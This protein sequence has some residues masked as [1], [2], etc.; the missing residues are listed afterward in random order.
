MVII[1]ISNS[2]N[3]LDTTMPTLT[4]FF[5]SYIPTQVEDSNGHDIVIDKNGQRCLPLTSWG[6]NA[7]AC[8][9]IDAENSSR[10]YTVVSVTFNEG[11]VT[12]VDYDYGCDSTAQ[13][14]GY[15]SWSQ[16]VE[17]KQAQAT[18]IES[19]EIEVNSVAIK[20]VNQGANPFFNYWGYDLA[21]SIS[22]E[23]QLDITQENNDS[24]N[25]QQF[26]ITVHSHL[27]LFPAHRATVNIDDS[28]PI[29]IFD[30]KP[31]KGRTPFDL[32]WGRSMEI[33]QEL[34]VSQAI[35]PYQNS[36]FDVATV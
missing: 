20:F 6:P 15:L 35:D 3:T 9:E 21:P 17:I 32:F 34:V 33:E 18:F 4:L 13:H 25:E 19:Y 22:T 11:Q 27:T 16:Q 29:P 31:E 8:Y 26:S 12:D 1:A 24:L 36:H 2:S 10:L 30:I 7:F 23:Y 28:D 5:Q 14:P